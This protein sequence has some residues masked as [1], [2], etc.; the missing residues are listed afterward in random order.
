MAIVYGANY[1]RP[2]L[3]INFAKNKSLIDGVS[4]L[5]LVSFGR[6]STGTYVGVDGL[7][8]TAIANEPRFDHDPVTGVC[9][10][11]LVEESRTNSLPYSQG[12][13]SGWHT[14]N[15]QV[16]TG[17]A[18]PVGGTNAVLVKQTNGTSTLQYISSLT[19]TRIT[20]NF[21]V[22]V[23]VKYV[24]YDYV[25]LSG[26]D[27]DSNPT[28][29]R[30]G[31]LLPKLR[32]Q[33]STETIA[34][35]ESTWGGTTTLGYGVQKYA[36]GWYRL[37]FTRS[38][39]V[40]NNWWGI[41]VQ[42]G[43]DTGSDLNGVV[44]DNSSSVLAF[45]FQVEQGPFPTTYIPTTVSTVTRSVDQASIT[46]TNFSRWY[47]SS[48]GT[49]L[50][51]SALNESTDATPS[52]IFGNYLWAT[53]PQVWRT[54]GNGTII[55]PTSSSRTIRTKHAFALKSND[56]AVSINGGA[57]LAA[58]FN[59]STSPASSGPVSFNAN[60]NTLNGYISRLTYWPSRLQDSQLQRLTK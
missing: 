24:N 55:Y 9:N 49:V 26:A 47:N 3:D 33:F 23:F 14:A 7:I 48:E 44:G 40:R 29:T 57:V 12:F 16:T 30:F 11:L 25:I 28:G 17:Q 6:G 46:G 10:G 21:T 1:G 2:T 52:I 53:S 4:G 41:A 54:T 5:N 50:F 18:D 60:G 8:K 34:F 58:S 42:S 19:S 56:H 43:Y 35:Q 59:N 27:E 51:D 36:N 45:G 20:A 15:A 37:W 13:T 31:Y 32:F 39:A 22:S 38:T